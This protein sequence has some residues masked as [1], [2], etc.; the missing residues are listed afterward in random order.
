MPAVGDGRLYSPVVTRVRKIPTL[1]SL[2]F[3]VYFYPFNLLDAT[4]VQS[5]MVRRQDML[6]RVATPEV[7]DVMVM[8]LLR[9]LDEHQYSRMPFVDKN[10][11]LLY[12][13]HR[14]ML[15]RFLSRRVRAGNVSDL[16]QLT[17]ADVFAEQPEL[18]TMF[19]ATAA[20]VGG[21][22]TLAEARI[23]MDAIPNCYDVFV[24]DSGS[25]EEPL[26]GWLTDVIIAASEPR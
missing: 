22:A 11:R 21:E 19:S 18:R 5:R 14:S 17:I 25:A 26:L 3:D 8:D 12:I 10:D 23:A 4:P 16:G 2:Q 7:G 6:C 1:G 9:E 20:F 24:T 13:A 15:D